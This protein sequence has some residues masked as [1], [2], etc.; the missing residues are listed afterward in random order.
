[1][2]ERKREIFVLYGNAVGNF[3]R[4]RRKTPYRTNSAFYHFV[5]RGLRRVCGYGEYAE[6]DLM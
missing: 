5:R 6:F 2:R 4:R 1:M 3:Y